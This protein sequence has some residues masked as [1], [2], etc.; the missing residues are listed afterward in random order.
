[1]SRTLFIYRSFQ[2]NWL[3]S[4]VFVMLFLF[5]T[6]CSPFDV[7]LIQEVELSGIQL[8]F[9][10]PVYE[11]SQTT[12]QT[13]ALNEK[14]FLIQLDNFLISV[15]PD[16]QVHV[17]EFPTTANLV[18]N[19]IDS[20]IFYADTQKIKMVRLDPLRSNGFE[21]EKDI[22][23]GM[24]EIYSLGINPHNNQLL[25]SGST[26]LE[27]CNLLLY[28]K[29]SSGEYINSH[30]NFEIEF[31]GNCAKFL[32][33][34]RSRYLYAHV[35]MKDENKQKLFIADTDNS[36]QMIFVSQLQLFTDVIPNQGYLFV[37]TETKDVI[38]EFESQLWQGVSKVGTS[39]LNRIS[40]KCLINEISFYEPCIQDFPARYA[41]AW[42]EQTWDINFYS[43][44]NTVSP[45]IISLP[46]FTQYMAIDP[47]YEYLWV[48]TSE[49][50]SGE[51]LIYDKSTQISAISFSNT[52]FYPMRIGFDAN[53][54]RVYVIGSSEPYQR[55]NDFTPKLLIYQIN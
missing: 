10:K 1:M 50:N 26:N 47:F 16:M 5:L 30:P 12:F 11:A 55:Y 7:I 36:F 52:N 3:R 34:W 41:R 44:D 32:T 40:P 9:S 13:I 53:L 46:Y 8:P 21:V 24:D 35:E 20:N 51:I 29:S 14:L 42:Q 6:A 25:V 4:T 49:N 54:K 22:E 37:R 27:Q 48:L 17:N 39:N 23:T 28:D 2:S 45:D 43:G 18:V 19:P 33:D 38:P 15:S 31:L